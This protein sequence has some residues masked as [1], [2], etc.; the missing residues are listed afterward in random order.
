MAT[1]IF[2][3]ALGNVWSWTK[4]KN[5]NDLITYA[6]KLN[7]SGVEITFSSKEELFLF[8]LSKSNKSWLKNLNYVTIHAPFYLIKKSKTESEI[9]KQ[10]DII[11]K[12]YNEINAQNVIIHPNDL[13][14]LK[15]LNRYNFNISTEN[16]PKRHHITIS[17]LRK[18]LNKYPKIGLCLD[19]SHAYRW[20]KYE[21]PNLIKAFKNKISQ[22]HFSGTYKRKEHQSLK[23]V[24]K[25][26]LYSL[27]SVK[28]LKVPIVI[29]EDIKVKDLKFVKNE[30]EYIK[31]LF[32]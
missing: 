24:T 15:I 3:F 5:R 21:T 30:I 32:D 26:F 2:S 18:I 10:L 17:D 28:E 13:L 12:I 7:V 23:N 9:I 1:R 4:S 6:R 14:P 16:L 25:D 19:V 22:V 8:K 29:E 31:K 11:S 27:Q 20:S